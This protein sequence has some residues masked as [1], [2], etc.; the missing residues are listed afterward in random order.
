MKLFKKIIFPRFRVPRVVISDSGSHSHQW[1]LKALLKKHGVTHKVGLAYH[2]KTS[3]QVEVSNRQIK[4]ILEKVVNKSRK[5]WSL[6]LDD[7]LWALILHT[8]YKTPLGTT[9]Y[10]LVYGKAC[11]LPVEMEYLSAWAVKEIKLDF[12]AAGEAD[13]FN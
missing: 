9:S 12:E 13:F 8:T 6:K 1:T 7:T 3:C 11:H 2:P 4:R 10:R 5:N